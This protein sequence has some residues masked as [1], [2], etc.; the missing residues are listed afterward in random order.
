MLEAITFTGIGR[1]TDLDELAG[2]AGRYPRAEFA[3]LAGSQ[4][5]QGDPLYPPLETVREVAASLP[6]TAVHL[7]GRYAR[8]SAGEELGSGL[9]ESICRDFG[10]VQVN[11]PPAERHSQEESRRLYAL[12]RFADRLDAETL[13]LQHREDW[14]RIP[15]TDVRFELDH[16]HCGHSG[17]GDRFAGCVRVGIGNPLGLPGE[18]DVL[19]SLQEQAQPICGYPPELLHPPP[20]SW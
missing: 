6:R 1:R 20:G 9:L 4:T 5:G 3:I 2:I 15:T 14:I 8:E 10:R 17:H 18:A 12:T 13:I 11:L 16:H 7:C 19:Y